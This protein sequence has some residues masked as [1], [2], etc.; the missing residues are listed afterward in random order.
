MA[1]EL[2]AGVKQTMRMLERGRLSEVMVAGDA[3]HFVTRPVV[4]SAELRHVKV[5]HID[6]KR[7]L[8]H[9]CGLDTGTAVAGVLKET[10]E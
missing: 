8:G 7:T 5:T 1:E 2:V 6:T 3:D 4:E 10:E 9:M